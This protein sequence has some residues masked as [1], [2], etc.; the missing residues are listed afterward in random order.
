MAA[1]L[2][3]ELAAVDR[4]LIKWGRYERDNTRQMHPLERIRMMHDGA[5]FSGAAP[6]P[7]WVEIVD[8]VVRKAPSHVSS[9]IV[10][11]YTQPDPVTVKA[12]RLGMGRSTLYNYWN[13]A[14]RY[15]QGALGEKI[16]EIP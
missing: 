2:N 5:V 9:V 12:S 6:E 16:S 8:T 15:V 4:V 1:Q 10:I 14:L 13:N 7:Q 3:P 11:W